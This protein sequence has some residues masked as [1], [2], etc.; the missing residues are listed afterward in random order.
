MKRGTR[1]LLGALAAL[2]VVAPAAHAA[3]QP[4]DAY[5]VDAS[6]KKLEQLAQMGYD[7]VE[8]RQGNSL[9]VVATPREARQLEAKGFAPK[10]LR[11]G[12]GR[13][14]RQRA[15]VQ[16]ENGGYAVY[17]PYNR[18]AL[19]ENAEPTENLVQ[20]L[21]RL[22]AENPVTTKLE[23]IGRSVL[24]VPIYA[25]KVTKNAR[26]VPDGQRPAVL[27]SSTQHAR[28]W[29]STDTNRRMM[30]MF[31][32][33]YGETGT[34]QDIYGGDIEG[35]TSEEL[36]ELVD[37]NEL[38][39]VLVCNPDGYDYTFTDPDVRL[40]RK[41]L[42]DNDGNG[43]IDFRDGVDPNRNFATHWGYD[44]EG[45]SPD[46]TDLTYRGTGPQSEPETQALDGLMKRVNFEFNSNY[47]T[48]AALLLY[49]FGWQMD[50][51]AADEPIFRAL[52]GT[53]EEPAVEGFNPGHGSEL[54][55]TNGDTNDHAY[56]QYGTASFTPELLPGEEDAE[57]GAGGFVFQDIP[58][59]AEREFERQ[60]QYG[61]DLARSAKD[62][63]NPVSHLG[64][65]A[66]PFELESFAVS[67]GDPQ[68]VQ[69][70]A[71]RELGPVTMHYKIGE[72]DEQT[73]STQEWKGGE[74][75]GDEGDDWYHRVRGT[76]TGAQ[77]GQNVKVWFDAGGK[78]SKAFTYSLASDD[79]ADVLILAVENY[80]GGSPAYADNTGPNYLAAY[81][82]A[83]DALGVTYDVYD[84]DARGLR[85]PD[86]LG[87][88]SHYKAVVWYTGDD[89]VTR[90]PG[91][92]GGTGAHKL[93][94]DVQ[95][96]VRD[97]LNEGGK[98]LLTGSDVRRAVLRRVRLPA[99]RRPRADAQRVLRQRRPDGAPTPASR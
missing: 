68:V 55:I 15:K 87:V 47:H 77:P 41:N 9:N 37:Q 26:S 8:G 22:A 36:T 82:A 48:A 53:D 75:Y 1:A 10:L 56:S 97:Y 85:A 58:E 50:T 74:R 16:G 59:D 89:Y 46:P 11:D 32:D 38:W 12:Q 62:P 78:T 20:E 40:W 69:V 42:R 5:R 80:T 71:K 45:S 70:N 61:L 21:K 28:E 57:E 14:A 65:D 30:R 6:G 84:T 94:Q 76:V 39:F 86:P 51:H 66:A 7:V 73:V 35:V 67:Y 4:L 23:I 63:A 33:N 19:D 54:Y 92:P 18:P 3:G 17:R 90:E 60:V 2:L 83:L 72:G 25:L 88:L 52:L 24:G 44:N 99:V 79:G 64:N 34:A 43:E 27:Y 98:L 96:A 49:P 31:I 91:Q 29:L 95:M 81:T 93:A 13:T